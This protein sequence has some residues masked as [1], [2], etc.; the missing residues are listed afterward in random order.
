MERGKDRAEGDSAAH[1]AALL[2]AAR[3]TRV[4]A[5]PMRIEVEAVHDRP[6]AW[7]WHGVRQRIIESVGPERLW[8]PWWKGRMSPLLG[9]EYHAAQDESGRWLWM[10]RHN[11]CGQWFLHGEWI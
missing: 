11:A 5:Q 7:T 10:Y 6:C 2:P 1:I 4:L 8:L 3:P 9:R